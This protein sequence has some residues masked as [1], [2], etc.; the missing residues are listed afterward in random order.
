M[1]KKI[2]AAKGYSAYN[3]L[4]Q[5]TDEVCRGFEKCGYDVEIVDLTLETGNEQLR[6]CLENAEDYEFYFSMQGLWWELK[7][8]EA[9]QLN[10]MKCV[11]WFV[12]APVYHSARFYMSEMEDAHILMTQHSHTERIC[13]EYSHFKDVKTLYHGGFYQEEDAVFADKDI[14]V[15]FSGTYVPPEEAEAA[16]DEIE[17]V[18]GTL[19]RKVKQRLKASDMA[20]TWTNE[21]KKLLEELQFTI[22]DEE[23]RAML[24]VMYPL[25]QY[26]RAY[27]RTRMVEEIVSQKITLSVVG[28]GWEK[29]Q[30]TGRE[31][32]QIISAVGVNISEAVRLM[33]RSKIVLNNIN[34]VDGMHERIFTA[35]LAKAVCLTNEHEILKTLFEDGKEVVTYPLEKPEVLPVIIRELL[36]HPKQLKNIADKGYQKAIEKH[37]WERRGEQI[38]KWLKDGQDFVY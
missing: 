28:K 5:A 14:D 24:E 9:P 1:K 34:F 22:S 7:K 10:R 2:L 19:A 4:R 13:L 27:M 20:D 8:N 12:D 32:L 33:Q 3:V 18:F 11:G 31:Y 38:V 26:Q 23:E 37:T 21:L 29:Y 6:K 35:M 36:E 15:F 17:G 16:V 25:D 30:G